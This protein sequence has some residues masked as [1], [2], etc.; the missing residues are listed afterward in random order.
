MSD[1]DSADEPGDE[2]ADAPAHEPGSAKENDNHDLSPSVRRL[3]RHYDL[4]I[5]GIRGSGPEGRIRVGDVMPLLGARGALPGDGDGESDSRVEDDVETGTRSPAAAAGG[6]TDRQPKT[7]SSMPAMPRPAAAQPHEAR[8]A[9]VVFECDLS[10]VLHRQAQ[11]Q[12][13]GDTLD[14]TAYI[15]FACA[16]A[17][18]AEPDINGDPLRVDLAVQ[19]RSDAAPVLLRHA[20]T[21]SVLDIGRRLRAPKAESAGQPA[22]PGAMS[23]GAEAP[24]PDMPQWQAEPAATFSIRN[25][26]D[27]GSVLSFP[28]V[29]A[30]Y[31][32]AALGVGKVRKIVA[33][34]QVNGADTPRITAQCYLS[35]S[36]DTDTVSEA[37]ACRYLSECVRALET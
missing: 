14:L 25:Y 35:L 17:L 12:A 7:D 37:Q 20:G 2:H 27:S 21:L 4:D 23:P 10:P 15:A 18:Q 31:T 3:V 22:E 1:I 11:A 36:F 28:T 26:G 32:R 29:P 33:V 19:A 24:D 8:I 16:A 34:K 30:P 5:T 6:Q 9:T 13:Q